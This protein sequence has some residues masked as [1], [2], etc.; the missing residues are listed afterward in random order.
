MFG[1]SGNSPFD[2]RWR[3]FGIPVGIKMSFWF[4][5]LFFGLPYLL[6]RRWDLFAIWVGCT[7]FSFLFKELGHVLFGRI[8]GVRGGIVLYAFGGSP[9]GDYE[10]MRRWQRIVFHAAGP[11]FSFSLWAVAVVCHNQ[12]DLLVQLGRAEI[13][14]RYVLLRLIQLNWFWGI[15]HL[16]PIYP[17]DGGK[18]VRELCEA[19]SPR[20]GLIFSLL[21]SL[22]CAGGLAAWAAYAY[23]K[24][25]EWPFGDPI[26]SLIFDTMMA[27]QNLFMLVQALRERRPTSASEHDDGHEQPARQQKDYEDYRP[28]DGGRPEDT[29]RR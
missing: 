21:I 13:P 22:A 1:L 26:F 10:S 5:C 24:P 19:V 6:L 11:A 2:L 3:M 28:F 14:V 15:I 16:L 29:E 23:W 20:F 7:L 4:F 12:S 9:V 25:A 8:F 17:L 27:V 18:I